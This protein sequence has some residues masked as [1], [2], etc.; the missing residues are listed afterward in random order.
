MG[1]SKDKTFLWG[2]D[3]PSLKRI[4]EKWGLAIKDSVV[5]LGIHW[6]LKPKREL[7]HKKDMMRLTLMLNRLQRLTYLPLPLRSKQG[8]YPWDV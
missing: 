2:T 1:I 5:C 6:P 7:E 4:A 3:D 8:L